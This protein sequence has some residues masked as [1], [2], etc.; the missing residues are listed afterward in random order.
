MRKLKIHEN[1]RYFM[2]DDGTPFYYIADTAWDMAHKLNRNEMEYY[3]SHRKNQ[4]FNVLQVVALAESDGIRIPNAYGHLPFLEKDGEYD[5][6]SIPKEQSNYWT[7]L[8][9]MIHIAAQND[10]FIGLLPTWGDKFNQKHGKGPVIFH[11]NNAYEYGKWLGRRYCNQWNIIWILGGD[12]PLETEEHGRIVDA[13]A[14]GL[15]AGDLGNHLITFHPSGASSSVDFVPKK[16]YMDF[17]AIQSGHGMECYDSW[18]L[19]KKTR[20]LEDK[21]CMDLE[22]R[23]ERF[24][25]CF[26][27]D[28]DCLW[29]SSDIRHNNYWNM[30]EGVC[31][32]TYGHRAV[33]CF[34]N[35][36]T[37]DEP[38]HWQEV[39]RDPAAEEIKYLKQL[40]FS[41]P[42]FELR[43]A[44]ELLRNNYTGMGHQCAGR[45]ERYVF[46]YSP[47]GLPIYVNLESF[48]GYCI[49]ASWFNPRNG[50]EKVFAAITSKEEVFV[51]PSSGKG[52]DW[53][54]ILDRMS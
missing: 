28:Y 3:M 12:R 8:D 47:L 19:L 15:K 30:M 35:Y 40:R 17:H 46:F 54:L 39:L 49:K 7:D 20:E 27:R 45:G 33:W 14:A 52:N 5:P 48:G 11:E 51:P 44:D 21:P 43:N 34:N 6:L 29:D 26:R 4:G 22:P 53:I 10:M 16:D 25:V 42:Y 31:G 50:E 38:H 36:K 32:H 13:M 41:R 9:D 18:K 23:Y 1:K 37:K 24:P 2:W